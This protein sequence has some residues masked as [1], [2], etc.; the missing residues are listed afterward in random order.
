MACKI[1]PPPPPFQVQL[2]R[3]VNPYAGAMFSNN[4]SYCESILVWDFGENIFFILTIYTVSQTLSLNYI[5]SVSKTRNIY[6]T[7]LCCHPFKV[8]IFNL[9]FLKYSPIFSIIAG[10]DNI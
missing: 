8:D 4:L 10:Y 1:P 7:F 6:F 9:L 3:K 2:Y 5:Y